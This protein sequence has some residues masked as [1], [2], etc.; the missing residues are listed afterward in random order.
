MKKYVFIILTLSVFLLS[1]SQKGT[2]SGKPLISVSILPQQYFLEQLAGKLI[3]INV[4]VPPG[5]SPATYDPGMAQLRRLE[6]SSVYMQIGYVGFEKSWMEKL[7]EINPEMKVVD[8]SDGIKLISGSVHESETGHHQAEDKH[9]HDH[10]TDPHIWMSAQNALTIAANIHRELLILFP[11]EK[12][13]LDKNLASFTHKA[14]SLDREIRKQLAGL[15][16]R[17]FLIFH[18]ALGYFARDYELEQYALELE[19]KTPSP[20][21][22]KKLTDLAVEKEI[23][24]IFIQKQFDRTNAEIIERETGARL[25]EFDPLALEWV[26]QLSRITQILSSPGP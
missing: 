9:H 11:G 12:D 22:L 26:N 8:L 7:R 16:K 2:E 4:M 13:Y 18:P 20:A 14:D 21:Y 15:E 3:E 6:N 24:T 19:G 1:C 17:E 25:V 10:G 5:A 23:Q